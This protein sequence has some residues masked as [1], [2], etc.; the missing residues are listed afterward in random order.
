MSG[1]KYI[2]L[3]KT[4]IIHLSLLIIAWSKC[5]QEGRRMTPPSFFIL[6]L[7]GAAIFAIKQHGQHISFSTFLFP[8][9]KQITA[10]DTLFPLHRASGSGR[11]VFDAPYLQ[12]F[13]IKARTL[14]DSNRL[15]H[16]GI[17]FLVCHTRYDMRKDHTILPNPILCT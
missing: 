17:L 12:I 9:H 13:P 1:N 14:S 15:V 2:L 11:E 10:H 5:G 4:A 3:N 16:R 7:D 6:T 8:L